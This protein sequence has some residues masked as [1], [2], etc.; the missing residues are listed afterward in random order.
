MKHF[1]EPD[2]SYDSLFEIPMETV[3]GQEYLII[4]VDNTLLHLHET[5]L[6]TEVVALLA[7]WRE[8][9]IK[10]I[11]LVSNVG[12]PTKKRIRRLRHIAEQVKAH[13]VPASWWFSKPHHRP[14]KKAMALMHSKPETTAVIG[15]Q[16]YTDIRGGNL[17]G[18]YTILLRP[19]GR[20]KWP[21]RYRRWL[22]RKRNLVVL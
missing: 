19:L 9:K 4:D 15:D 22:E 3:P 13:Y 17:L 10:G 12:I 6:S 20:D 8:H 21:T 18:L 16:L 7:K 1:L 2:A 14:F 11:C 5:E